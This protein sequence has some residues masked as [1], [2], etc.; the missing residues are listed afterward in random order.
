MQKRILFT[1]GSSFT[2]AWFVREL[3]AC[4]F[5]VVAIFQRGDLS[6]YEGVRRNRVEIVAG[7]ATSS[8]YGCSF[9][10]DQFMSLLKDASGGWDVLCHHG[11][12][13]KDYKSADFNVLHAV[14]ENTKNIGE[15][16]KIASDSQ[17]MSVVLTGSIFEQ[18]EGAGSEGLPAISPYGLSKALTSEIVRY[19][20]DEAGVAF[21]KFVIPN[22]FGPLAEPKFTNFLVKTWFAGEIPT[23]RTPMYVRDNIEVTL[24]AKAYARFVGEIDPK[25]GFAKF[26]PSGYIE[27]QGAFAQRF[28]REM[29]V[30][31]GIACPV[32]LAE[33]VEFSEPRIRVNTELV[34]G[35]ALGWDEGKAWDGI[36]A[37]YSQIYG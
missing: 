25:R 7:C 23:V 29:E 6:E 21:G 10:D 36:A 12:Y 33:Q 30:R 37:Y 2:G 24:L 19:Y 20:A 5:E 9:G 32:A 3:C 34:N 11:A 31:L 1:G 16:I 17:R 18:G 13:V 4:G 28:G 15:V 14:E 27:S 35:V 26:N 22:P 8:V